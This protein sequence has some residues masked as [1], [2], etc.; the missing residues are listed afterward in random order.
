MAGDPP[1]RA[2]D[3]WP[4][5]IRAQSEA[6]AAARGRAW[7]DAEP[8]LSFVR[9]A[10]VEPRPGLWRV[11]TVTVEA[12]PARADELTLGLDW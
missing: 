11:W 8:R 1:R 9:V 10:S 4:L 6:D 5:W 12:E 3:L 2:A 7:A